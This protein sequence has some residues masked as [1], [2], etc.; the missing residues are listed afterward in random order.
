MQSMECCRSWARLYAV[1]A[2]ASR[3]CAAGP[4]RF[5]RTAIFAHVDVFEQRCRRAPEPEPDPDPDRDPSRCLLSQ[6]HPEFADANPG[7]N[8][9]VT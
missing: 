9:C 2:A 5:D 4:W 8:P 6:P 7:P 3:G 1:A